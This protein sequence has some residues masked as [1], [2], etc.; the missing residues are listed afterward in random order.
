MIGKNFQRNE[1]MRAGIDIGMMLAIFRH[2]HHIETVLAFA[3]H[4]ALGAGRRQLIGAAEKDHALTPPL[5]QMRFHSETLTGCT[6]RR[7]FFTSIISA[8]FLSALT[9]A[10]V[11]GFGMS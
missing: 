3:Q 9:S 5:A 6:E 7:V 8:N 11:T 2:H 10:S 4:H 1:L